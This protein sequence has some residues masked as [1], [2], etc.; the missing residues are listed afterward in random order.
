MTKPRALALLLVLAALLSWP[1]RKQTGLRG[2][3][4]SI[5]FSNRVLTDNL[6]TEVTYRFKTDAS[7]APLAEDHRVLTRLVDRGQPVVE[8]EFDPPVPTSK[9]VPG[10]DVT[11]SRRM[12]IPPFVDEFRPG[13]SGAERVELIVTLV[14]P[15]RGA[16]STGL[17]LYDRK[18]RIAAAP[19]S[20]VMAFLSG[21]HPPQAEAGNPRKF[22]RWTG[23]EARVAI[24][25][26]GHDAWLVIR[27]AAGPGA[28][29]GQKVTLSIDSRV[30]EEFEPG[31]GEFEKRYRIEKAWLADR[32]DFV[33][34]IAVD[35]TFA[36]AKETPGAADERELGIK[37]SLI[38]FK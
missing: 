19:E 28:P 35:K 27:G 8:D 38:Y 7:F 37:V 36:S 24:D 10:K 6:F 1:C 14:P 23:R 21:W 34:T 2:V 9:W 13:F 31:P 11:F 33:L 16:Q 25:N 29:P 17:V 32:Q 5:G 15:S 22:W 12:Y 3:E 18:L 20:P 26:P 4:V 30:L